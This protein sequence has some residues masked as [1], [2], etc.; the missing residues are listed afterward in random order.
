MHSTKHYYSRNTSSR[1]SKNSEAFASKFLRKSLTNMRQKVSKGD[2]TGSQ[3][4]KLKAKPTRLLHMVTTCT[5]L[6]K[7]TN[8]TA[9]STK[10]CNM[11]HQAIQHGAPS[12]KTD[13]TLDTNI[14]HLHEATYQIVC[15]HKL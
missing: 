2:I 9:C 3:H 1:F 13:S 6:K 11:E 5:I 10:Q 12:I 14:Q 7:P 8:N 15:R 4:I